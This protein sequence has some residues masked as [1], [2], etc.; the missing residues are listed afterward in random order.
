MLEETLNHTMRL[1]LAGNHL[2]PPDNFFEWVRIVTHVA[3]RYEVLLKGSNLSHIPSSVETST[4]KFHTG[5]NFKGD[6]QEASSNGWTRPGNR[7][8]SVHDV[9]ASGD[10]IMGGIYSAEILRG[11][12]G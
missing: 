7:R 4:D 2:L 11:P 1:A 12:N 5:N 9:D 6:V 10:T 3:Q 8:E